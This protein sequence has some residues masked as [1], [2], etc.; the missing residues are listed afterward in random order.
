[1][2]KLQNKAFFNLFTLLFY[3]TWVFQT[4]EIKIIKLWFQRIP[5]NFQLWGL[6][7]DDIWDEDIL[8]VHTIRSEFYLDVQR[9]DHEFW[10]QLQKK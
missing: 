4:S 8:T 9:K 1:M 5:A 10:N 6:M 2:N 7:P 3:N